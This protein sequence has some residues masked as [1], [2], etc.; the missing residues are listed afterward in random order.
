MGGEEEMRRM[1]KIGFSHERSSNLLSLCEFSCFQLIYHLE[2][3]CFIFGNLVGSVR[4]FWDGLEL[5]T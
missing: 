4:E 2:M 1:K 5:K 3:L